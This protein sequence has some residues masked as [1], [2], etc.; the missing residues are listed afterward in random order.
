MF[1]NTNDCPIY[2]PENCL[3]AYKAADYWKD[4]SDRFREI[5]V[6]HALEIL[7][8]EVEEMAMLLDSLQQVLMGNVPEE[9]AVEFYYRLN[10]VTEWY[11]AI[12]QRMSFTITTVEE[13]RELE[14]NI[15]AV[16]YALDMLADDVIRYIEEHPKDSAMPVGPKVSGGGGRPALPGD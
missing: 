1:N 6:D 3:D 7:Q 4:Y 14:S 2:V 10:E 12:R 5:G 15:Q 9:E 11:M 13:V 16:R 8:R